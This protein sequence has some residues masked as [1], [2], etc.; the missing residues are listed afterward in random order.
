[1]E[2]R[3]QDWPRRRLR[4]RGPGY[5]SSAE[6]LATI[7]T[8]MSAGEALDL[9]YALLARFGSLAQ[10]AQASLADLGQVPGLGPARASQI[11]AA[12]ELGRRLPTDGLVGECPLIQCPGDAARFLGEW[13]DRANQLGQEEVH[14]LLLNVK[15]RLIGHQM[16]YRGTVNSSF[17][18]AG[19]VLRVAVRQGAPCV[20]AAHNHPS[21][22]LEPSPDDVAITRALAQGADLLGI[23]LCDHLIMGPGGH[24]LS[25]KERGFL[26]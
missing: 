12:L 20:I 18:N 13:M 7:L 17:F 11:L 24:F 21:A 23:L 6:L 5:L 16:V 9:G 1:M 8:G 2:I 14:V 25:L 19:D 4:E 10:L 22:E 3:P 15:N 26:V